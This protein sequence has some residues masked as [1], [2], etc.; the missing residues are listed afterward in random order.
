L[1]ASAAPL[2]DLLAT[3]PEYEGR[4]AIVGIFELVFRS[5]DRDV[6]R[7]GDS[8]YR[9]GSVML[10]GGGRKWRVIGSEPPESWFADGRYILVPITVTPAAT[11]R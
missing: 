5:P 10:D 11:V 9:S 4:E 6:V 8:A 3:E 1:Q 7:L 2:S